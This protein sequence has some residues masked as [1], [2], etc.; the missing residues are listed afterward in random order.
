MFDLV[1]I[2]LVDFEVNVNEDVVF[3]L[4]SQLKRIDVDFPLKLD[5]WELT[6]VLYL[7]LEFLPQI[8]IIFS[9]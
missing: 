3:E 6:S 2:R 8:V 7:W 4:H 5:F 1:D 9:N